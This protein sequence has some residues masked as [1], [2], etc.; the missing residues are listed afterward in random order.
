MAGGGKKEEGREERGKEGG[1]KEERGGREEGGRRRPRTVAGL[2]YISSC[3][4]PALNP[5]PSQP[6]PATLVPVA[7]L[8]ARWA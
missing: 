8:G 1:K 6:H 4:F 3:S 7:V 5:P 2:S